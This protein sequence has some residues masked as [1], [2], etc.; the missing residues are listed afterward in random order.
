MAIEETREWMLVWNLYELPEIEDR[1]TNDDWNRISMIARKYYV[2]RTVDE[3]RNHTFLVT[4]GTDCLG[5]FLLIWT[6]EPDR[7]AFHAVHTL[8]SR[9]CRGAK[10]IEAGKL[11]I[12]KAF[13]LE[14][15][16][17]LESWCPANNPESYLFARLCGFKRVG[18]AP[19]E[20]VKNMQRYPIRVVALS[21][22]EWEQMP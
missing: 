17:R 3:K 11:G 5:C 21:R 7:P 18:F 12:A 6:K 10:A 22:E 13:S 20:W 19:V 2:M 4:S 15:V 1:V 9:Q 14:D 8:L 16:E